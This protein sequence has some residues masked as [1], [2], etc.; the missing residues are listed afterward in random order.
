[1]GCGPSTDGDFAAFLGEIADRADAAPP[2]ER[3]DRRAPC[4]VRT[5]ALY[6]KS[7]AHHV[8]DSSP[9]RPLHA[10]DSTALRALAE[11]RKRLEDQVHRR[12]VGQ[13]EVVDLLLCCLFAGGHGL[14]VGVPGLA[15]TMLVGALAEAMDLEF[16]RIQF[17]PDLMPADI[18]GSEVLEED[19][20]TG[21]RVFRFVAGP[22]FCNLLLA[23]EIN[24]TPPKTQAALLQSMQE[25][26][27]SAGGTTHRLPPPF[28]VFATQNPIEQEGTY[29]LPE[30]QLDRFMLQI[31]VDY[32]DEDA[33]RRIVA[34]G[35]ADPADIESVLSPVELIAHQELVRRIP[36]PQ[37]VVDHVVELLR[38]SR[39]ASDTAPAAV[40][41]LLRWGA[42]PRAGQ[43]LIAAA[44][45]RAALDGRPAV[46]VHDVRAL[47]GAVLEHRLVRSFVAESR[48]V[49][50]REI[51]GEILGAVEA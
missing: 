38:A 47:A 42:G 5:W 15:K 13:S 11:S 1:M 7:T 39:P 9:V 40:K 37:S 16:S 28:H 44:Q 26:R 30:A 32:P 33:E 46:N 31:V 21:K 10:D 50:T 23:D 4:D 34:M 24:R 3:S 51:M 25:R 20:A 14:F 6:T 12:I 19:A 29:P 18:T 41:E 17:T 36:V 27:V 43:Q 22:V 48:G 45:A 2:H 35:S 49:T 8:A